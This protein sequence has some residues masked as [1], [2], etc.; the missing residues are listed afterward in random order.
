MSDIRKLTTKIVED[1]QKKQAHF[2]RLN[3]KLRHLE[4]NT[5]ELL[6]FS[7]SAV[8]NDFLRQAAA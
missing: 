2:K 8:Y 3:R 1:A 4:E 5:R 6:D 7:F